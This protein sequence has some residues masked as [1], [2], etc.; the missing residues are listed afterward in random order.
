MQLARGAK[1][2]YLTGFIAGAAAE[3]ARARAVAAGNEGD[4]AAVSS[5][6][7]AA[8]PAERA[9]HFRVGPPVYSAQLDDFYWRR[10]HAPVAIVDAMIHFN[11]E[12]LKQQTTDAL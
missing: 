1:Q 5:G 6:A 12:M 8:L 9:L 3:Q 7:M 2:T 11:R 4:A 10:N